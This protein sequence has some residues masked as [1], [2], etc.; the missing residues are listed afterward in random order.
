MMEINN[1]NDI[2]EFSQLYR[3]SNWVFRGIAKE[4]HELRPKIG[5]YNFNLNKEKRIFEHFQRESVAYENELP[6]SELE[7]LAVAQH[8]GLPTRLLDWTENIL[9]AAYFA[10][11]KHHSIDGV[12]HLL[13]CTN[14]LT[15]KSISP[16]EID[17]ITRYRP[18]HIA[19]RISAQRGLFTIHPE[20]NTPLSVCESGTLKVRK[21]IIP[22]KNKNKILWNLSRF[23]VNKRSL[24]PDLGGLADHIE[25]MFTNKDPSEF[26]HAEGTI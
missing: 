19:K 24:F 2:F 17:K 11:N 5:R 25:W 8:Y 4:K 3:K 13:L 22:A 14:N 12:I 20:P 23:D 21:V 10:C 15:K 7:M 9:V 26:D 1:F 6:N 18:R 16:F